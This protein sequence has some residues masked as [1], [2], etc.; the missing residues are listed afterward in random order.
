[1]H[2]SSQDG[3]VLYRLRYVLRWASSV[4]ANVCAALLSQFVR[5]LFMCF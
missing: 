5:K 3:M 4:L 2:G 1:M